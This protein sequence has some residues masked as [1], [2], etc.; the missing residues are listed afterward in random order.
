MKT[1]QT[2]KYPALLRD[3]AVTL[4]AGIPAAEAF[5]KAGGIQIEGGSRAL[6]ALRR[7]RPLHRVL[8]DAGIAGPAERLRLATAEQ[9]GLLPEVLTGL[10]DDI[11]QRRRRRARLRGR[12]LLP[13]AVLFIGLFAVTALA[14]FR[15]EV[16]DGTLLSANLLKATGVVLIIGVVLRLEDRD[17]WWWCER[18]W[19]YG[20]QRQP[21]ARRAFEAGW[22]RLLLWQLE[23]GIDVVSA[24]IAMKGL[25]RAPRYERALASAVRQVRNGDSLSAALADT[26]LLDRGDA[27]SILATGERSGRLTEIGLHHT[28]LAVTALDQWLAHL[29]AWLPRF[30]YLL[31]AVVALSMFPGL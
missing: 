21:L 23:A 10:A 30:V 24:L 2:A 5:D 6:A 29:D 15:P 27:L 9:A 17:L 28:A 20:L 8:G 31:A 4:S 18:A 11:E 16:A 12:M 14:T 25:I 3:L 22:L 19:R 26:G 1:R 7:G 13:L